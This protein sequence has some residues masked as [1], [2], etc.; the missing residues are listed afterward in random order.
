MNLRR[1]LV[2]GSVCVLTLL[3]GC[4]IKSEGPNVIRIISSLPRTGSAQGQ[5]DTMVNGIIL[6]LEEAGNKAGEFTIRYEDLDDATAIDGKWTP[7]RERANAERAVKHPDVMV[8]IGPYNSGAADISIPILNR[9]S[10]LMIS[11][12]ATSPGLSKPGKGGPNEPEKHRPTGKV[13]FTR[14]VPADDLQGPLG[15]DWTKELGA[16]KVYI[17]HDN[18]VYGKGLAD[19]YRDRCRELKIEVLGFD[20]IDYKQSDFRT[21]MNEVRSKGPGMLYFGGTSQ[22]GAPQIVKDMVN[23]GLA[24]SCKLMVPD[25]CYEDAFV[26][27]AGKENFAK[28]EAYVTFGGLPPDKLT[29]KGKTFY[30]NYK[31]RFGKEPEGYAVYSYESARVA[32]MAIEKAGKKDRAAILEAALAIRDFDGALGVWSFDANGDTTMATMS[33]NKIDADGKPVFQ[34]VLGSK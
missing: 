14:T 21:K 12:A 11:P 29:G 2:A 9:A 6:A 22:T 8:Y 28:L 26:D 1:M 19:L 25:G 3:S 17:L 33:G 15:A 7:Q 30:E 34:K 32:L 10:L 23:V 16:T 4:G 27:G 24:G 31:K 5:T 20:A 13:N 18:E